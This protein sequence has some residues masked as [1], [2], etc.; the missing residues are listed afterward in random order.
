MH[1]TVCWLTRVILGRR[2]LLKEVLQKL[3]FPVFLGVQL[4]FNSWGVQLVAFLRRVSFP[5][6]AFS[7][8]RLPSFILFLCACIDSL[9]K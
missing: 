4:S 9:N 8:F 1:G 6:H 2:E 5:M 7:F 3:T